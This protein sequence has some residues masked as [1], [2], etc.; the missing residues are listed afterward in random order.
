MLLSGSESHTTPSKSRAYTVGAPVDADAVAIDGWSP[1]ATAARATTRET[2][3][4]RRA[5]EEEEEEEEEDARGRVA[6]TG[7]RAEEDAASAAADIGATRERGRVVDDAARSMKSPRD[8]RFR[9]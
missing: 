8:P 1:L 2:P 5:T 9:A 4:S 7:A 6:A 3:R